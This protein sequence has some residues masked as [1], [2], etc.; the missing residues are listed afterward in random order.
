MKS[1]V[2]TYIQETTQLVNAENI[3][4]A[5]AYAKDYAAARKNLKV[6]EVR[7]ATPGSG[8]TPGLIQPLTA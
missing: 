7:A 3:G 2:V 8:L 5:G 6:L 1:F 4:D